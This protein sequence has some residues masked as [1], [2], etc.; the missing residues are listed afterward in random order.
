MSLFVRTGALILLLLAAS[1]QEATSRNGACAAQVVDSAQLAA[2]VKTEFLH[3][4]TGHRRYAWARDNPE[5]KPFCA[6]QTR[7]SEL[8]ILL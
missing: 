8:T 4:W 1:L 6:G 3:A 7:A 2:G 5:G